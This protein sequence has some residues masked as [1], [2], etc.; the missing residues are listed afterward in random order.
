MQ[1]STLLKFP[2][3]APPMRDIMRRPVFPP[4]ISDLSLSLFHPVSLPSLSSL[5]SHREIFH[6]S[7]LLANE[8]IINMGADPKKMK[9]A[10]I[11]QSVFESELL[12]RCSRYLPLNFE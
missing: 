8:S 1:F 4:I 5:S 10:A 11:N 7:V 12:S 2:V 9:G 3:T 6:C